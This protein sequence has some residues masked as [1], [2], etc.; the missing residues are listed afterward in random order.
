MLRV[1]VSTSASAR[2]RAARHF[3]Q[4]LPPATE[5]LILGATR[6]AADDLVRGVA[7]EAGAT[8]GL[9]RFSLTEL[10]AKAASVATADRRA[11]ATRS[12]ADAV[13][14]RAVFD[15]MAAGEL[16]YFTP[17][18]AMPGFSRAVARTAHELRLGR[19]STGDLS[20]RD[21]ASTD[22]ARLLSRIESQFGEAAVNDRAALFSVARA[23]IASGQTPWAQRPIVLLDV[24]VDSVVER[25]FVAALV[26]Q[27]PS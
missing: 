15:A 7:R 22:I 3:L 19:I 20:D 16:E 4:Q 21:P 18:A 10:A 11:P 1:V 5:T 6:G 12:A 9:T 25:Q 23:A 24:P 8:F 14:A 2:L 27:S 17:V 26:R 13:A